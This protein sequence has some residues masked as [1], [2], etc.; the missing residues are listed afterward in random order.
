[1]KVMPKS[2]MMTVTT[3]DSKYSRIIVFGGPGSASTFVCRPRPFGLT[4]REVNTLA[5]S[6]V[7]SSVETVLSIIANIV[8]AAQH[9]RQA[10][11]N[12]IAGVLSF[13]PFESLRAFA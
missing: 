12:S 2:A 13:A 10:E 4:D 8:E 1:M 7:V 3:A 11:E 6:R 5:F 9:Y